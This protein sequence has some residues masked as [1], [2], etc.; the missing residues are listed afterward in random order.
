MNQ[1]MNNRIKVK[2]GLLSLVLALTLVPVVSGYGDTQMT[3]EMI[4]EDHDD[5]WSAGDDIAWYKFECQQSDFVAISVYLGGYIN[6]SLTVYGPSDVLLDN[7]S[8]YDTAFVAS[9]TGA[10]SG[11]HTF[12]LERASSSMSISID[13]VIS[14]ATQPSDVP[15]YSTLI[16][17]V[18][19]IGTAL[20]IAFKFLRRHKIEKRE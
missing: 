16:M 6:G 12:K 10:E 15:G 17:L 14:G 20:A 2:F 11:V 7:E 1:F 4:S 3:A 19:G 18:L 8:G 9:F 5:T 13:I